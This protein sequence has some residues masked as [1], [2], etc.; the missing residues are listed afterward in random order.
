MANATG[1][2]LV[3]NPRPETADLGA[4][5][6][7]AEYISHTDSRRSLVDL[8]YQF[9]RS[10]SLNKKR[11]LIEVETAERTVLDI[12]C[13]TGDFLS[14]MQQHGWDVQGMEPHSGARERAE[15]KLNTS[16]SQDQSL[17]SLKSNSTDVITMWHVMEH[18]PYP[19][20]T[21]RHIYRILRSG[22]LAVIAVPNFL[23][24]D[25]GY[26]KEHWAA[27]DVPRHLFHF[28]QAGMTDM[29]SAQGFAHHRTLPLVFD[30]FYVSLLSEKYKSGRMQPLRAL[31]SGIRSNLSARK[32]SEWSSLLYIFRKQ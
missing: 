12:G 2:V 10:Y 25:A 3:T 26:Y 7:S 16:I 29:F 21:V 32:T 24:Y 23:S 22:G 20:Q 28:S 1:T 13:G 27:Y 14:E 4:Y 31:L 17:E 5:Y 6:E 30:S 18:V 8:V 19:V 11:R 15:K 9:V